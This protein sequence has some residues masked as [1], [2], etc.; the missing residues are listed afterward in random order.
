MVEQRG[1]R[2]VILPGFGKAVTSNHLDISS[3]YKFLVASCLSVADVRTRVF[4]ALVSSTK[5]FVSRAKRVLLHA[6]SQ[7]FVSSTKRIRPARNA[8]IVCNMISYSKV[9][10]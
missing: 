2:N 3:V 9:S 7:M 4:N 6:A 8:L 5:V 1:L 10:S